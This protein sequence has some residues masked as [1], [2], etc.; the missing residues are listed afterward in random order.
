M[1]SANAA[2]AGWCVQVNVAVHS[3]T[4]AVPDERL[5]I[6]RE[7]IGAVAVAACCHL[8]LKMSSENQPSTLKST[9]Y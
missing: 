2:A 4:R 7:L 5:V 6:E 8:N 1:A 9:L 3:E